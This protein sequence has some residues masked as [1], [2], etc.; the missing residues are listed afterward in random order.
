ML[1]WQWV[2]ARRFGRRFAVRRRDPLWR[3]RP[4]GHIVRLDVPVW[5]RGSRF[6]FGFTRCLFAQRVARLTRRRHGIRSVLR[7]FVFRYACI[8]RR[9]LL[10]GCAVR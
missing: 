4:L 7:A 2:F 5:G 6:V 9:R 1:W 10:K 3:Q 8:P